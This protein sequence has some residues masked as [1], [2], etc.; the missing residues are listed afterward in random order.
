M[1]IRRDKG[2]TGM[3][4]IDPPTL[5]AWK[6]ALLLPIFFL[7]KRKEHLHVTISYMLRR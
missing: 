4:E 6:P 2:K 7:D 5:P 3:V 1:L